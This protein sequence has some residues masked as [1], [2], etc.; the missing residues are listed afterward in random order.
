MIPPKRFA[1]FFPFYENA[2]LINQLN[3]FIK[4]FV[5]QHRREFATD[6]CGHLFFCHKIIT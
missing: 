1:Y 2:L 3:E 5:I 4:P 6:Y